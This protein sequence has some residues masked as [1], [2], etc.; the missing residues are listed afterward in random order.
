S[1]F[2][3]N[4]FAHHLNQT[5]NSSI[6]YG[7]LT[8]G[9]SLSTAAVE[10]GLSF[11]K[12]GK[13]DNIDKKKPGATVAPSP[14]QEKE[15]KPKTLEFS[16]M[17]WGQKA[18]S[19]AKKASQMDDIRWTDIIDDAATLIP[20]GTN[21]SVENFAHPEAVLIAVAIV[22]LKVPEIELQLN[23]HRWH[24]NSEII[25]KK[26]SLKIKKD[27]LEVLIKAVELYKGWLGVQH[28]EEEGEEF[29]LD[30]S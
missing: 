22:G 29:D 3:L 7:H 11:W 21:P 17:L 9:L 15:K 20:T 5:S 16:D 23:W 25:P 6:D 1:K 30:V 18:Q 19:W 13:F 27:K 4:V 14:K 10:R 12:T 2:V 26:V 24:G 8:G 28:A